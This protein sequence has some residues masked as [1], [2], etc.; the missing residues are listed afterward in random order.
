MAIHLTKKQS[1]LEKR[2]MLLHRQV[3]GKAENKI[4]SQ[5]NNTSS[6]DV[7]NITYLYKDLLKIA[8]L[9]SV[10]IGIQITLYFL[11]QNHILKFNLF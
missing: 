3:Y 5:P 10:A 9:S 11:L 4:T 8:L 1:D 6:T 7:S 2:L